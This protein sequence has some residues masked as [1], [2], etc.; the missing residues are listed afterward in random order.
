MIALGIGLLFSVTMFG[1]LQ[2][3]ALLPVS[4]A[5]LA[6]F[7]YPLLTGLAGAATGGPV[8]AGVRW[9]PPAPRSLASG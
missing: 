6:Y 3:I 7:V 1:L 4:I 5:I 8:S 2:S 9:P